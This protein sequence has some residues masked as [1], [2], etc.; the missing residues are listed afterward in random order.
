M[1]DHWSL[2]NSETI[3]VS[4]VFIGW[5]CESERYISHSLLTDHLSALLNCLHIVSHSVIKVL[6]QQQRTSAHSMGKFDG[7]K[8]VGCAFQLL[9]ICIIDQLNHGCGNGCFTIFSHISA[10][11]TLYTPRH[12]LDHRSSLKDC[13][14]PWSAVHDLSNFCLAL[15]YEIKS[16]EP[17]TT[18]CQEFMSL[19]S[20][21]IWKIYSS[22]RRNWLFPKYT[23]TAV[24][25][26]AI[27][28]CWSKCTFARCPF[29]LHMLC[30]LLRL[31]YPFTS[32]LSLTQRQCGWCC[33]GSSRWP[34]PRA[35]AALT[36]YLARA[37]TLG[38]FLA[39]GFAAGWHDF[40]SAQSTT[41]NDTKKV[42]QMNQ[43]TCVMLEEKRCMT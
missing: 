9:L 21:K 2:K 6:S 32:S 25:N 37:E 14:L 24:I 43:L 20:Y 23:S 4:E 30:W 31:T 42:L 34:R 12:F 35:K 16:S 36:T 8:W 11:Y 33:K 18:L 5:L 26:W 39:V 15:F 41:T 40:T 1:P 28:C 19:F 38:V 13:L 27:Y 29:S 7:R 3:A 22:C 10:S 17:Q